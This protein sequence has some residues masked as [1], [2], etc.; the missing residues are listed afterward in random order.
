M[1]SD[2]DDELSFHERG[3]LSPGTI[4]VPEL[5][6]SA[7]ELPKQQSLCHNR[8]GDNAAFNAEHCWVRVSN[9][10][11]HGDGTRGS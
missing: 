11:T 3:A 5:L 8:V 4:A 6:V 2:P 9:G 7:V 1:F 10:M